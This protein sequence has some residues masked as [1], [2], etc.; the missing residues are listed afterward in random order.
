MADEQAPEGLEE[1]FARLKALADSIEGSELDLCVTV[2]GVRVDQLYTI[3][4]MQ[5][6]A[7]DLAGQLDE[8][9]AML[10]DDRFRALAEATD[11]M[12]RAEDTAK[13]INTL[14][15]VRTDEFR[16]AKAALRQVVDD[17]P[18]KHD[19]VQDLFAH[20]AVMERDEPM[21]ERLAALLKTD[22]KPARKKRS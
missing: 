9:E 11:R 1:R 12:V 16:V 3:H 14:V 5:D 8:V 2:S 15:A 22:E 10:N 13:L 6:G 20:M 4:P 18:E 21:S 7:E 19:Q 17:K